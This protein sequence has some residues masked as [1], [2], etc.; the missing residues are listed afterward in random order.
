MN[1]RAIDQ[2]HHIVATGDLAALDELIGDDAVFSSPAV[3]T[4]QHGKAKTLMYLQAALKVFSGKD[5]RYIEEWHGRDSAVLEFVAELDGVHSRACRRSS[6]S[7][8]FSF[9]SPEPLRL[10]VVAPAYGRPR[11]SMT[12]ANARSSAH[13]RISTSWSG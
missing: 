12:S 9:R 10:P 3:F 7:W 6:H 1:Q 5:F 11:L 4:P 8:V 2:W 13:R